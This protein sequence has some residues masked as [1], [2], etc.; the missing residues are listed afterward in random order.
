MPNE[1]PP[2]K[3]E[4]VMAVEGGAVQ[5]E[6]VAAIDGGSPANGGDP[7]VPS[8][9]PL[10]RGPAS[11]HGSSSSRRPPNNR[12]LLMSSSQKTKNSNNKTR[13]APMLLGR[14][15]SY[16]SHSRMGGPPK[17]MIEPEI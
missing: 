7:H 16:A 3:N 5:N 6:V 12:A 15:S 17:T 10:L 11:S 14:L 13:T 4:V 1:V 9:C 8:N 2:E